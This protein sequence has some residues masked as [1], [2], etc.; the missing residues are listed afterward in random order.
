M[1][2]SGEPPTRSAVV[3][4]SPFEHISES[5]APAIMLFVA[6]AFATELGNRGP[7]C[8]S[9]SILSRYSMCRIWF[10]SFIIIYGLSQRTSQ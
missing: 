10:C 7:V 8:A 3:F 1:M 4:S 9:A 6:S 5:I 2:Y